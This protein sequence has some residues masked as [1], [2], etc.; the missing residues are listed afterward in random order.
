[1]LGVEGLTTTG[2]AVRTAADTWTTT[3]NNSAN[4]DTAHSERLRWDGGATGL[5][6]ATGRTSL[7]LGSLATKSTIM[8]SDID[9]SAALDASKIANGTV[10]TAEFQYLG[11]VTSDI[12]TQLNAK[13]SAASPTFTGVMSAALG[14]ATAPSY[15]FTGDTNTGMWSATA[16]NL[17]LG[18]AGSERI[19]INSNG[20]VGIGTTTP[21]TNLDIAVM[22][23]EPE[24]HLLINSSLSETQLQIRKS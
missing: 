6:A 18:T 21:F 9:T 13:A 2:L 4:W 19:T 7:G 3:A 23:V 15:T 24:V 14:S 1:M 11:N 22:A 8:N 17:S 12:Q 5:V 10:S 16:D 20:N